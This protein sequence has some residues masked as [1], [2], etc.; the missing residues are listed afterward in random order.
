[1]GLDGCT[2][3]LSDF[4]RV[5]LSNPAVNESPIAGICPRGSGSAVP[6]HPPNGN[7]QETIESIRRI[8]SVQ[9]E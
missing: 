3:R 6:A 2:G 7:D 4:A 1:M 8:I 9:R 5:R